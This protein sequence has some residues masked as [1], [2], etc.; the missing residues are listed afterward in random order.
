MS[1]CLTP[2][3][4]SFLVHNPLVSCVKP[5]VTRRRQN[6]SL[7]AVQIKSKFAAFHEF[8]STGLLR[9]NTRCLHLLSNLS[10]LLTTLLRGNAKWG[11]TIKP[12]LRSTCKQLHFSIMA[13]F[14]LVILLLT[15]RKLSSPWQKLF[16]SH[17][18][19]KP[20]CEMALYHLFQYDYKFSQLVNHP[21][22]LLT[23]I[24]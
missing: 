16:A 3:V 12:V 8:F 7:H 20:K 6:H 9:N 11:K 2:L 23:R 1:G 18:S 17:K 19:T 15:K 5:Q 10:N 22:L 21:F 4:V 24:S 14:N 13:V